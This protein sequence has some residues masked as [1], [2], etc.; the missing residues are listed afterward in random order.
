M[1]LCMTVGSAKSIS[2]PELAEVRDVRQ[3]RTPMKQATTKKTT[4]SKGKGPFDKGP[5]H[6]EVLERLCFAF[7][8][9]AKDT[10]SSWA[11]PFDHLC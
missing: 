2:L 6:N 4:S 1:F 11:I 5:F 9:G 8:K 10:P 3:P 7:C